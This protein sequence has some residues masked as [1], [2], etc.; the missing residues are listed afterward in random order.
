MYA[1]G[2]Q[3]TRDQTR[4]DVC[5]SVLQSVIEELEI[6]KNEALETTWI[7][8]NRDFGSIFSTLL[9]GTSAKLEPTEGGSV[10]EGLEVKVGGIFVARSC[11]TVNRT[12]EVLDVVVTGGV[13]KCVEGDPDRIEWRTTIS[14]CSLLDLIASSVQ[15]STYVY[16]G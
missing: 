15:A 11:H 16:P 5:L 13:W 4:P 9:P 7:K 3:Y 2:I 8:V 12:E 14:S 6:K 1:A 10:L